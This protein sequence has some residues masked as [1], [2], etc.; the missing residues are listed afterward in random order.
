[1]GS[2]G[3]YPEHVQEI[4]RVHGNM[5]IQHPGTGEVAALTEALPRCVDDEGQNHLL[6]MLAHLS[7]EDAGVVLQ[8]FAPEQ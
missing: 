1:M 8:G 4:L 5:L 6:D 3:Q 7:L 2:E